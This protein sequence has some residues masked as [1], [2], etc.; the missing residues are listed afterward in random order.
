MRRPRI[1]ASAIS[2][3][4]KTTLHARMSE[5]QKPPMVLKVITQKRGDEV[6]AVVVARLQA[7]RQRVFGGGACGLQQVG[8]ELGGQKFVGFALV[9]QQRQLFAQA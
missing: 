1:T 7:Q 5:L 6:I 4:Q 8:A 3:A 2:S 9:H